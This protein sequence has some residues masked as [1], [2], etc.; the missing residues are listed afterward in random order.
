MVHHEAAGVL[1]FLAHWEEQVV[2]YVTFLVGTEGH[3]QHEEHSR[4]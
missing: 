3:P 1:V 2:F 4:V